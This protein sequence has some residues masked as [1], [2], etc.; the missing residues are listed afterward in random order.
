MIPFDQT[1]TKPGNY[2]EAYVGE[3]FGPYT[4][5]VD[6]FTVKLYAFAQD[7]YNDWT[8]SDNN[9]FGRRIAQAG[10]FNNDLLH[11]F[12]THYD[13]KNVVALH[14]QEELWFHN[15]AYVSENVTLTAK[16]VDKYAKRGRN[17]IELESRLTGADGR[18]IVTH[19][20]VEITHFTGDQISEKKTVKVEGD[21]VTGEFDHSI[22][23]AGTASETIPDGTP[24]PLLV[25]K[26]TTYQVQAFSW[27]G[28]FFDTIHSSLT[29]ARENGYQNIVVQGQQ[30]VCYLTEML[31][32]FFGASWY[33]SGHL[34]VKIIRPSL[35]G[36]ILSYQ[37]F[38]N[39]KT[40]EEG[41][42]RL[43]L[44]VWGKNEKGDMT[45]CGWADALVNS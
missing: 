21:K 34:K 45:V 8:F 19:R 40:V 29:T 39:R 3:T 11:I 26:T 42:T 37:G 22:P 36:E 31:V 9:P 30:Q 10:C 14:T 16:Y 24:L 17:C 27:G 12:F 28:M 20:G 25:K 13:P 4:Y 15:P 44:H 23:E 41:G 43:H 1:G 2:E 35:A 32:D 18:P 5:P 38:V 6:D 7:D 33:T